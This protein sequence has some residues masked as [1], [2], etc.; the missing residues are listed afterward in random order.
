MNPNSRT[1][2]IQRVPKIPGCIPPTWG[3]F[4]VHL[5][6]TPGC[7][8]PPF[9][10][11]HKDASYPWH[12]VTLGKEAGI[13]SLTHGFINRP[14]VRPKRIFSNFTLP[15]GQPSGQSPPTT[16]L[17]LSSPWDFRE[18][19]F[20]TLLHQCPFAYV[21]LGQCWAFLTIFNDLWLT[22]SS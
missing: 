20:S 16:N 14:Y 21:N 12:S 18:F 1:H 4:S 9:S 22:V 7:K 10:F 17:C 3:V 5:Y 11:F 8:A 19:P 13:T 2:G 15:K 6:C